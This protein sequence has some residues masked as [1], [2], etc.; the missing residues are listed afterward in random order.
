MFFRLVTSNQLC[1]LTTWKGSVEY[2]SFLSFQSRCWLEVIL[3]WQSMPTF[4][5]GGS[6]CGAQA[7]CRADTSVDEQVCL[8]HCILFQATLI[9][10][11]AFQ[12]Y[13]MKR[14]M[15]PWRA[16]LWQIAIQI[17]SLHLE[18]GIVK[19]QRAS[20]KPYQNLGALSYKI[21]ETL[22]AGKHSIPILLDR[23]QGFT[24][25]KSNA[26]R[27][28]FCLCT[29]CCLQRFIWCS[30][31]GWRAKLLSSLSNGL[32]RLVI[33]SLI[34]WEAWSVT[35]DITYISRCS[36]AQHGETALSWVYWVLK[37]TDW[38]LES[39]FQL[40]FGSANLSNVTYVMISV[41]VR[42]DISSNLVIITRKTHG[43][44]RPGT[45]TSNIFMFPQPS[46][47]LVLGLLSQCLLEYQIYWSCSLL[48]G[49]LNAHVCKVW[50]GS[51]T[52]SHFGLLLHMKH[53]CLLRVSIASQDCCKHEAQPKE[54]L[55]GKVERH[56]PNDIHGSG[57]KKDNRSLRRQRITSL[58]WL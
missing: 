58:L 36:I 53:S 14:F 21:R 19:C 17:K 6:C 33:W 54:S 38:L 23:E 28:I 57:A 18:F 29:N 27:P 11:A 40:L 5:I 45:N 56:Q 47:R 31:H 26:C 2:W 12:T 41:D 50:Y 32:T 48:W 20:L 16:R 1:R 9:Q 8:T 44:R 37:L 55:I 7:D 39:T 46:S 13:C 15:Q 52:G 34:A 25:R 51:W 4:S 43:C 42:D 49:N 3:C 35:D 30:N 10:C 24:P 22:M